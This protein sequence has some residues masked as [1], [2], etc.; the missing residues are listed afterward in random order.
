M[1][2]NHRSTKTALPSFLFFIIQFSFEISSTN[3]QFLEHSS[4][5]FLPSISPWNKINYL[6]RKFISLILG[7]TIFPNKIPSKKKLRKFS[8]QSK[9]PF[10]KL[11]KSLCAGKMLANLLHRDKITKKRIKTNKSKK[12]TNEG[13]ADKKQTLIVMVKSENRLEKARRVMIIHFFWKF[14][15][16]FHISIQENKLKILHSQFSNNSEYYTRFDICI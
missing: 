12:Q 8:L 13:Y 11:E 14:L 16:N 15:V 6:P 5:K 2:E 1:W 10:E 7:C 3:N 9:K 4:C